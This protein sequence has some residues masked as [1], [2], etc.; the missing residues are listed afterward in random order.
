MTSAPCLLAVLSEPS[1]FASISAELS[2][3]D[4]RTCYAK[5]LSDLLPEDERTPPSVVL[6]D[7]DRL[8]W[9]E[10]LRSFQQKMPETAV[11]FLTR[12][13]DERLWLRML[14][15][16]A[17]DLLEKPYR[18]QDLRWVVSTALKRRAERR[19]SASAA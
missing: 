15:A 12:T 9:S 3:L 4:V 19:S 6:C 11:V 17:F 7:A 18:S 13:A 1:D 5:D 14:E 10:T 2:D 8:N 16:G